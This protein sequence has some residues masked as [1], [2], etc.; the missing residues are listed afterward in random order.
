[1]LIN[2]SPHADAQTIGKTLAGLGLWVDALK[3][4][5]GIVQAF[6][7]QAGSTP[8]CTGV[9][10]EIP[11]VTSILVPQSKHPMVDAQRGTSASIGRATF[12]GAS[13]VLIAGPC[14]IDE[15]AQWTR[16]AGDCRRWTFLR[17]GAF[18]PRTSPTPLPVTESKHPNGCVKAD[19]HHRLWSQKCF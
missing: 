5:D 8:V 12:G 1:M 6:Q 13:P 7:V 11:G 3:N 14:S 19:A 2:L 10:H 15:P 9:L 17:G 18:K 16:I 4:S